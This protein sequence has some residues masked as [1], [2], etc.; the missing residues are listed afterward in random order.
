MGVNFFVFSIK[1]PRGQGASQ[2]KECAVSSGFAGTLGRSSGGL[3]IGKFLYRQLAFDSGPSYKNF[4]SLLTTS[5]QAIPTN[6][7]LRY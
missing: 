3:A 7:S 6:T 2:D 5:P 1:W 4:Q